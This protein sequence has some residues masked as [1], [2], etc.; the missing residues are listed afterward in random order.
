MS[1]LE[2]MMKGLE[3][4]QEVPEKVINRVE[5]VLE[6]LPDKK[7]RVRRSW[8]RQVA[9]ATMA[10][11][12]S[13]VFCYSH[14]ALAAKI[15]LIGKIFERVE[16]SVPFSGDYSEKA[17]T[18]VTPED[19]AESQMM[20]TDAGISVTASEVYC[21]GV[22]VFLA[23]QV[24]VSEENILKIPSHTLNGKTTTADGMY[25]RGTWMLEGE[26]PKMLNARMLEG[27]M[28]DKHTFVGMLKL[29]LE[30]KK[31]EAGTLKLQLTSIGWDQE[32]V[33][34][35]DI[36]ENIRVDGAWSF[37]VPFTVDKE[38]VKEIAVNQ[39]QNGYTI[40]K[41]I[42]SPYQVV[43]Y[44]KA[45][46]SNVEKQISRADYEGKLG[47]AEGEEDET[48]SYEDFVAQYQKPVMQPCETVICNQEGELLFANDSSTTS[49]TTTFAVDKKELQKLYIYVLT[50]V[51]N[52]LHEDGSLNR[53]L[54]TEQAVVSA[55]VNLF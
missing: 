22:S 52:Y 2:E 13:G 49:G 30:E 23:A 16:E 1:Y 51:E 20:V 41:I 26:E 10:I 8:Q 25:L 53:E 9:A 44:V 27:K 3:K 38:S 50:D 39:E 15:P 18:L 11:V 31:L 19:V 37:T 17:E 42:V 4:N 40:Q 7:E 55:E 48:L 36:S 28:V 43:S 6:N 33:E 24:E 12:I 32:A 29:D 45:P 5:L 46:L 21:D 35:E 47:L 14:P 34:T 54:L